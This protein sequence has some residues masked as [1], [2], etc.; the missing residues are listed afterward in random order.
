VEVLTVD[1]SR[2]SYGGPEVSEDPKPT[3]ETRIYSDGR[4][5]YVDLSSPPR[6]SGGNG[7]GSGGGNDSSDGASSDGASSNGSGGNGR[8]RRSRPKSEHAIEMAH[9]PK[10][11]DPGSEAAKATAL[12]A[13]FR[14]GYAFMTKVVGGK[15]YSLFRGRPGWWRGWDQKV[16]DPDLLKQLGPADMP[17]PQEFAGIPSA[18]HNPRG[19]HTPGQQTEPRRPVG[20]IDY[21]KANAGAGR[22]AGYEHRRLQGRQHMSDA[23]RECAAGRGPL[24]P[25]QRQHQVKTPGPHW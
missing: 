5:E 14:G 19:P 21:L 12:N 25:G 6:G 2:F 4:T 10:W 16:E 11:P 24:P 3:G 22:P 7:G 8:R 20:A 9:N 13:S 23:D 18:P 17:P 15:R 1:G